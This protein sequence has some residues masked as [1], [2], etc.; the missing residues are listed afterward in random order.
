MAKAEI[1]NQIRRLRFEVKETTQQALADSVGCTRQAIVVL[2]KGSHAPSLALACG[3]RT[4]SAA[5]SRK[6]STSWTRIEMVPAYRWYARV[7][8]PDKPPSRAAFGAR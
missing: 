7:G 6:C 4:P 1:R 3:S 5:L 8:C 2:D